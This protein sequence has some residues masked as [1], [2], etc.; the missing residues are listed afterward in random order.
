MIRRWVV[1]LLLLVAGSVAGSGATLSA[2]SEW[3]QPNTAMIFESVGVGLGTAVAVARARGGLRSVE[4]G[5][6]V[7]LTGT[8]ASLLVA[9]YATEPGQQ[10]TV[11]TSAG[12]WGLGGA[13]VGFATSFLPDRDRWD[14]VAYSLIGFAAGAIIGGAVAIIADEPPTAHQPPTSL[15]LPLAIILRHE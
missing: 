14:G 7:W 2:Q 4:R 11:A 3:A 9:S 5:A 15:R 10:G 1:G 8:A 6:A 12:Q 13:L